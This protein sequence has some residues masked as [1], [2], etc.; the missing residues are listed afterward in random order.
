MVFFIG[1]SSVFGNYTDIAQKHTNRGILMISIVKGAFGL[2]GKVAIVTGGA[3]GIGVGIAEV[4]ATA[5]ATVIIADI[6]VTA[7][8]QAAA[9]LAKAGH[10]ADHV[11]LNLSDEAS[12]TQAFASVIAK[13][14]SPW[15]VVN[16]AGIQDRQLLLD[17]T[18]EEWDRVN[19]VNSRGVF[20]VT[21]EAARAMTTAGNGGRIVN[22]ASAAVIGSITQGHT[23]YA[24]SKAA[25]LG[26]TR[27]SALELAPQAITV[28]TILPGGVATPGAIG[29][30]GPVPEGPGRRRPPLGMCTPR[31]I[32]N[33]VLFF[34]SPLS[35]AITNQ[36]LA[37]DGGWSVT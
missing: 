28:N 23:I 1:I 36:T 34:A 16:N 27:A 15:C 30:K 21:R 3:S 4:L 33:A 20:L 17:G 9:A 5:G 29:A 13:H 24:A 18:A 31:D 19:A 25:I 35:N 7:A 8:Q 12:I 14:G 26:L 22:I 37:V 2:D 6:N 10:S 11:Q 32:G